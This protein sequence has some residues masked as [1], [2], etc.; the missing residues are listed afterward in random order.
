M[1]I[2]NLSNNRCVLY[3][4]YLWCIC[5]KNGVSSTHIRPFLKEAIYAKWTNN[6][7]KNKKIKSVKSAVC[8][9]ASQTS[10]SIYYGDRRGI[11]FL[12][13]IETPYPLYC[14]KSSWGKTRKICLWRKVSFKSLR[15]QSL[16]VSFSYCSPLIFILA[17]QS[18]RWKIRLFVC[19]AYTRLERN[20]RFSGNCAI[21]RT[22]VLYDIHNRICTK[23][24][25]TFTSHC[26]FETALRGEEEAF[27]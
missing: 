8:E 7:C 3:V 18:W 14:S 2:E 25:R 12:F 9:T 22:I 15:A 5:K 26:D 27:W 11:Q 1:L 4:Q 16:R 21:N 24:A 6:E 20:R 23:S 19:S 13:Y 17:H 10:V